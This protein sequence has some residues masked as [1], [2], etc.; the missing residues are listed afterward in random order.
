MVA[1]VVWNPNKITVLGLHVRKVCTLVVQWL[2]CWII[3]SRF[4]P[5]FGLNWGVTTFCQSRLIRLLRRL[6]FKMW[7]V[8]HTCYM[9]WHDYCTGICLIWLW[10]VHVMVVLASMCRSTASPVAMFL[11]LMCL[12]FVCFIYIFYMDLYTWCGWRWTFTFKIN[13]TQWKSQ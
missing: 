1:W 4:G 9:V 6:T 10:C 7:G 8:C 3:T 11:L 5:L 12:A 2:A 13:Q